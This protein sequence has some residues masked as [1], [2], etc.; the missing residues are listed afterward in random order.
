[1][2]YFIFNEMNSKNNKNSPTFSLGKASDTVWDKI[3]F[4]VI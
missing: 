3:N 1:M 2:V 4:V